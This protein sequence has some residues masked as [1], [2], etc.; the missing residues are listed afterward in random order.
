[1]ISAPRYTLTLRDVL[2]GGLVVLLAGG[3]LWVASLVLG[4]ERTATSVRGAIVAAGGA[5]DASGQAAALASAKAWTDSP[6]VGSRARSLVLDVDLAS[7]DPDTQRIER[8][9]RDLASVKPTYGSTWQSLAQLRMVN[10]ATAQDVLPLVRLSAIMAPNEG[11]VMVPRAVFG[12][13]NWDILTESD[14]A[15]T[16]GD[17]AGVMRASGPGYQWPILS[18]VIAEQDAKVKAELRTRLTA[19]RTINPQAMRQIGLQ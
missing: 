11:Q 16:I 18:E 9:L 8:D 14:K 2:S 19:L 7:S 4:F 6:L 10:G 17:M 15:R 1:M 13:Q 3:M 5:L 12:I